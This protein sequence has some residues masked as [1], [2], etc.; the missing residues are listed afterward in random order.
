MIHQ[1]ATYCV[2]LTQSRYQPKRKHISDDEPLSQPR[3]PTTS[4]QVQG[5]PCQ[6]PAAHLHRAPVAPAKARRKPGKARLAG[7]QPAPQQAPFS[8][9]NFPL[10]Y[11]GT[12]HTPVSEQDHVPASAAP[13]SPCMPEHEPPQQH[14]G[15][16]S[17]AHAPS[18]QSVAPNNVRV[19]PAGPAATVLQSLPGCYDSLAWLG[20]FNLNL[21][22]CHATH[23]ATPINHLNESTASLALDGMPLALPGV[24]DF[25]W[26]MPDQLLPRLFIDFSSWQ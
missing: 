4:L 19:Q 25:D 21:D 12:P 17:A 26:H 23:A 5:R 24:E 3:G 9:T 6:A 11:S 1:R 15:P 7:A 18:V 8:Q 13:A 22:M 2:M 14:D 10:A 16:D 20:S